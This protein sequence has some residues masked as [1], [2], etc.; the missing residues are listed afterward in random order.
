M[1]SL[2]Y[3]LVIFFISSLPPICNFSIFFLIS[4][5]LNFASLLFKLFPG[6]KPNILLLKTLSL[7]ILFILFNFKFSLTYFSSGFKKNIVLSLNLLL[8]L[9]SWISIWLSKSFSISSSFAISEF[10]F[11]F[12]S[13][14]LFWIFLKDFF[15]FSF[16]FSKIS[17]DFFLEA[18]SI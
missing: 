17:F 8:F 9:I 2:S 11:S 7:T 18:L 15:K 4:F 12:S 6:N 5:F 1:L 3:F 10:D 13:I 14:L 16:F